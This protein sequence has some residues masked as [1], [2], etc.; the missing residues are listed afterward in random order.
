MPHLII[1]YSANIEQELKLPEL[2]ECLHDSTAEIEAFPRAGLRTRTTKRDNF[3][4][5]DGHP[6][7]SFV[8]VTL[9]IKSGRSMEIKKDAAEIIFKSLTDYLSPLLDTNPLAIS[10]EIQEIDPALSFRQGNIREHL[11]LRSSAKND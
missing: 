2:I 7:N 5:A 1:E 10:F 11:K 6:D 4:I 3:F 9:R 8:H